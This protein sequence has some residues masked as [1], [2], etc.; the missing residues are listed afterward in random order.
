MTIGAD[1][2]RLYL[3][4]DRLLAGGRSLTEIVLAA[5]AGG[6]SIVQIREKEATT[7][8]FVEQARALK[9]ALQGSAV[10]LIVNDRLDVALAV[11][12]DGVHLGDD[13]L[14]LAEARRLLGPAA[15][16]GVSLGGRADGAVAEADYVAASP[17]FTTGTKPDAGP[18]LGLA[19]VRAL[20]LGVPRPLIAIGGINLQNAPAIVQA[21]ADGIAVVS[22]IMA[23]DDPQAAAAALRAAVEAALPARG[24]SPG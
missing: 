2:L 11:G 17:V 7:R 5:V 13:D 20:R 3:V 4:T 24:R 6:V 18:A 10:P 8:V 9:A 16:I 12:A 1:A 19:G 21:G 23:A 14:P 15:I 22:A